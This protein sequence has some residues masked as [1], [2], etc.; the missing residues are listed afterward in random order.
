MWCMLGWGVNCSPRPVAHRLEEPSRAIPWSGCSPAEPAAVSPG[1]GQYTMALVPCRLALCAC[2]FEF[3]VAFR[4]DSLLTH[5]VIV[6][7]CYL[8]NVNVQENRV[9]GL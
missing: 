4:E 7:G 5:F 3:A 1:V 6:L 8:G 9:V 2:G